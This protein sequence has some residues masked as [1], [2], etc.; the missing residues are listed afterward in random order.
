MRSCSNSVT[1]VRPPET[2]RLAAPA[3]RDRFLEID[4][5][6]AGERMRQRQRI[7][8]AMF[9]NP[10]HRQMETGDGGSVASDEQDRKLNANDDRAASGRNLQIV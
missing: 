1:G 2:T 4:F 7:R 3:R 10:A 5:D 8:K 9:V 6:L